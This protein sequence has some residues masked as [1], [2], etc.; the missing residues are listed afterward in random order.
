[1]RKL[2][3]DFRRPVHS[4]LRHGRRSAGICLALAIAGLG[5]GCPKDVLGQTQSAQPHAAQALVTGIIPSVVSPTETRLVLTFNQPAPKYFIVS[6]S[7]DTN[8][9]AFADTKLAPGA[10]APPG[11]LGVIQAIN[12]A[13]SDGNLTLTLTGAGQI[14]TAAASLGQRALSLTITALAAA[15][16][17]ASAETGRLNA[18]MDGA[19]PDDVF[20]V[21]PLKYADV[22]EIVGLLTTAQGVKP[23]DNFNPQEPAFGSAGVSNGGSGIAAPAFNLAGAN[24]A[25][26]DPL[27]MSVDDSVGI[28]RRLN[29]IVLTG[30]PARVAQL[31]ARIAKLD[32]PVSS[33]ILETV[34]VELTERG[35]RNVGFDFANSSGQIAVLTYQFNK[36]GIS[37]GNGAVTPDTTSAWGGATVSLQAALAAQVQIG[38]GRIIS[39]PRIAAQ[40]GSTAKIITGDALPILTSIALSGVNAVQ[41]QVQYVNVGVTLQIAP[42]ISEDG[43]VTS[44][45]FAEVSSVTGVSQGY[46][47]ISQREASTMATV[48]DGESFVIGGLIQDSKLSTRTRLPIVGSVPGLGALFSNQSA[49]KAK[50]DLYIIVTPHIIRGRDA[51][52]AALANSR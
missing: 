52:A 29:A 49:S 6:Q 34:F 26:A 12:L 46:P 39:K 16:I 30:S 11:K 18:H 38:E 9:I 44:H 32:V 23:N 28:D 4:A 27:G 24:G 5:A 7:G 41:Q 36:G 2:Q 51:A 8:V 47:T 42:R 43:Y 31:K 22:S 13:Q 35:A 33:V 37:S 1:M 20:E 40:S 50:T 19:R 17:K 21:V 48:K 45:V 15:P 3:A 25:P 14:R 10:A